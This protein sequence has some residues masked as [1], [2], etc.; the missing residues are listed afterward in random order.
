M[1]PTNPACANCPVLAAP[2]FRSLSGNQAARLGCV[3]RPARYRKNQVLFF[4]GGQAEHLFSVR[5]GLVKLMKSLENGRDRIIRVLFPGEIF[6][7]ESLAESNYPL[8][9]IVMRDSE[10]CSVS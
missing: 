3:L 4:E 5:S 9:A 10:I 1:T 7:F 6:G 8:T 2:L